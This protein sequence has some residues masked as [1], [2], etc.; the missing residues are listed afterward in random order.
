MLHKQQGHRS[1]IRLQET[2][3]QAQR[4]QAPAR[5]SRHTSAHVAS[6]TFSKSVLP[7][8]ARNDCV[9]SITRRLGRQAKI[10]SRLFPFSTHQ[11]NP[12]SSKITAPPLDC[13]IV[14]RFCSR[15]RISM[16]ILT[17][18]GMCYRGSAHAMMPV[19]FGYEL[20]YLVSR[21]LL[22]VGGF[23]WKKVNECLGPL[24][25]KYSSVTL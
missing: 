21:E 9:K 24:C 4:D 18:R 14:S 13:R 6:I 8:T 12:K 3:S 7:G 19:G 1:T 25:H 20:S 15:R 16:R 10:M 23:G 22:R 11:S 2:Q 17:M 5:S